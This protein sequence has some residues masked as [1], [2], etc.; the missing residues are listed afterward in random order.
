MQNLYTRIFF[1]T[2]TLIYYIYIFIIYI[3]IFL[4]HTPRRHVRED[5]P[6]GYLMSL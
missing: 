2:Y 6:G 1:Y 4:K 3:N 5:T